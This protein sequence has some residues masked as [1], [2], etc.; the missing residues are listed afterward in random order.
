MAFVLLVG[1]IDGDPGSGVGAYCCEFVGGGAAE[2]EREF[3][4]EGVGKGEG[5]H[6]VEEL[7]VDVVA[8]VAPDEDEG[9][10]VRGC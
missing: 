1:E 5:G 3:G 6:A 4:V 7:E 2:S 8:E 9:Y 10:E